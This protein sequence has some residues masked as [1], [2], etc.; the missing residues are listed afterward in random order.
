MLTTVL[1]VGVVALGVWIGP[2]ALRWWS[3][4]QRHA[5]RSDVSADPCAEVVTDETRA[6]LDQ[7][8]A[9]PPSPPEGAL[10]EALALCRVEE[11][12]WYWRAGLREVAEWLDALGPG[13]DAVALH[14]EFRAALGELDAAE[15]LL[16]EV[17]ADHW[18]GCVVRAILY[19]A[20]GDDERMEAA[21][22]AAHELGPVTERD[23]VLAQLGIHR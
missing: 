16:A 12:C 1:V 5:L 20:A 9:D 8:R 19:D 10:A 7:L 6:A 3:R 2:S 23:W 17:P 13:A 22:V 21:L 14:A 11:P 18:R 4:R 15:A